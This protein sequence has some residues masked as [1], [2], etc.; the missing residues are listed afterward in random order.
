MHRNNH[1]HSTL[2]WMACRYIRG[3][4]NNV[5]NN[6]SNWSSKMLPQSWTFCKKACF[7]FLACASIFIQL[8]LTINRRR[9]L[10]YYP[11]Q[12]SLYIV[13]HLKLCSYLHSVLMWFALI[14]LVGFLAACLGLRTSLQSTYKY[15]K[16]YK[17]THIYT[18]RHSYIWC[19]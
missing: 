7:K 12:I 14:D 8:K 15:A 4:L 10:T 19:N 3:M 6:C 2:G 9:Q 18:I 13:G 1:L 5:P 11:P 16:F 17:Y